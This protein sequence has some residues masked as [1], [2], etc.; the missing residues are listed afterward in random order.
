M[1][2]LAE[3]LAAALVVA[4]QDDELDARSDHTEL[5]SDD[6][7]AAAWQDFDRRGHGCLP[8]ARALA[9]C[10]PAHLA[11]RALH[12]CPLHVRNNT[13]WAR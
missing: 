8:P 4:R 2:L 12:E 5:N 11:A 1:S 13:G 6:E 3:H 9:A 7:A 10:A